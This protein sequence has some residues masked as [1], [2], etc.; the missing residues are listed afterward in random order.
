MADAKL[1]TSSPKPPGAGDLRPVWGAVSVAQ[2]TCLLKSPFSG[3]G[4]R[5]PQAYNLATRSD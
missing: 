3:L 4:C 1:L 2:G 5:V